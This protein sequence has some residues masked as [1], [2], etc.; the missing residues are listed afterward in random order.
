MLR[1]PVGPGI[2][3]ITRVIG[4]VERCKGSLGKREYLNISISTTVWKLW[5]LDNVRISGNQSV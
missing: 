1:M 4:C 5:L 3:I 2:R